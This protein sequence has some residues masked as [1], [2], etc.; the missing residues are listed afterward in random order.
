MKAAEFLKS[1]GYKILMLS[2]EELLW[3]KNG[4]TLNYNI[5]D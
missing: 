5:P 1:K 2:R 4:N 3:V